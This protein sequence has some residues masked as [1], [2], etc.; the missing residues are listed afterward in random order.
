MKK[1]TWA[2]T[3]TETGDGAVGSAGSALEA[4][5]NFFATRNLLQFILEFWVNF[6]SSYQ[7]WLG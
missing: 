6:I 1:G 7:L 4:L 3:I 5:E 2:V